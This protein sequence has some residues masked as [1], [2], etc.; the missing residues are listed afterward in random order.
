MLCDSA[1]AHVTPYLPVFL[2]LK[3]DF[4]DLF[5][6][7]A[8]LLNSHC[9]RLL[10]KGVPNFSQV[11][12]VVVFILDLENQMVKSGTFCTRFS[13][14]HVDSVVHCPGTSCTGAFQPQLFMPR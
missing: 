3:Y 7:V 6:Q 4:A 10:S 12:V 5:L 8:A 2:Q 13:L 11:A 1:F 9:I 14:G